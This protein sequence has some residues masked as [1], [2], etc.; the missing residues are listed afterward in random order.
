MSTNPI[1]EERLAHLI[2]NPR[3]VSETYELANIL[4]ELRDRRATDS[5]V[6]QA[7]VE[8]ENRIEALRLKAFK[9]CKEMDRNAYF[10]AVSKWFQERHYRNTEAALSRANQAVVT[11]EIE[12]SFLKLCETLG[13]P[14]TSAA[15]MDARE[16]LAALSRAEGQH[17]D[18]LAVDRF[19]AAMKAKLAKKRTEG[20]GGWEDKTQCTADFLS[21]LLR[22]HVDKGDPVDVG[23]LAMMLHQ[24]GERI[25]S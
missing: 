16:L 18:D 13:I 12:T 11:E 8:E 6:N 21:K 2:A 23:N 24:R 22:G 5:R 25:E 9:T 4:T 19:A 10:H 1:S 7:V 15:W 14:A 17:P 20:R 3:H